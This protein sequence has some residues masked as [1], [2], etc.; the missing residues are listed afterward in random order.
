VVNA[1]KIPLLID[2]QALGLREGKALLLI[3]VRDLSWRNWFQGRQ[4]TLERRFII[5]P[6]KSLN[7]Y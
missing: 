6:D 1:I 7:F 4:T 5:Y 3:I 2:A